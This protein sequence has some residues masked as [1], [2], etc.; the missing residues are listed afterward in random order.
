MDRGGIGRQYRVT[1]KGDCLKV[2]KLIVF[3]LTAV[4]AAL[5]LAVWLIGNDISSISGSIF[6]AQPV[7]AATPSLE[8]LMRRGELALEEGEWL[9]ADEFFEMVLDINP[10][11]APAYL[12]KLLAELKIK[13]EAELENHAK[14]LD[15]M[16]NYQ[17]ALS[18]ADAHFRA[19]VTGYNE[20]INK[21]IP[22]RY[23]QVGA[24]IQFGGYDWRVL[25]VQSNSALII[26]EH[27]IELRPY[28]V[29]RA[30]V[31]WATC[32]LHEYL[33]GELLQ[34]FSIEDKARIAETRNNNPDNLWYGTS[35]GNDTTDKIFLLSLEEVDRYF[36]NS[37][38]YENKSRIKYEGQWP[39]G[40]WFS[41]DDGYAFSNEN[42]SDRIAKH[43]D[44][45]W[46]WWLRSPGLSNNLAA[47]V[48]FDGLISVIGIFAYNDRGGVRPALWLNF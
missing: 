17:K 34:K 44:I 2:R 4:I 19:K 9:R 46:F 22:E 25:D 1:K 14:P 31:T 23:R 33:N 43:N 11:Y 5:S 13:S 10:E 20:A 18:F 26:T 21:R 37:G 42:D 35:G 16:L 6:E 12:G 27:V 30:D 39:S 45:A 47:Y 7:D 3:K 40:K 36:G 28:N 48:N 38:D 24:I 29:E 41:A 15:N 8:S 32:D